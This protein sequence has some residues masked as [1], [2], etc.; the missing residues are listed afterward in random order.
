[1]IMLE[2]SISPTQGGPGLAVADDLLDVGGEIGIENRRLPAL[3]F[4]Q[5]GERDALGNRT[6]RRHRR[7]DHGYGHRAIV[8]DDLG[9]GTNASHKISE[10]TGCIGFQDVNGFHAVMILGS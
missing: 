1:M 9:T 4:M 7:M 2:S 3:F 6:A 5:C 10:V 8:D